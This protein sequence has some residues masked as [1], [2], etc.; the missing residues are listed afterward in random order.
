MEG[1]VADVHAGKSA[2]QG[3]G[4]AEAERAGTGFNEIPAG[5]GDAG[6]RC[7]ENPRGTDHVKC[8]VT[9]ANR[10]GAVQGIGARSG[11]AESASVKVDDRR[12]AERSRGGWGGGKGYQ[13]ARDGH[14]REGIRPRQGLRA[15]AHLVHRASGDQTAE[16]GGGVVVAQGESAAPG[17]HRATS[18]QAVDGFAES[19][20]VEGA[21]ARASG[22][23]NDRAGASTVG[24]LVGGTESQGRAFAGQGTEVDDRVTRV[25]VGGASIV[26][27]DVEGSGTRR[28]GS[29]IQ[30]Q[31][32]GTGDLSR[33]EE[34]T[35]RTLGSEGCRRQISSDFTR[36]SLICVIRPDT[37][38]VI[39][40][41]GVE[42]NR[43]GQ[44][45]TCRVKVNARQIGRCLPNDDRAS[46]ISSCDDS[47][48]CEA[49]ACPAAVQE[50][51]AAG[52]GV[53]R[54]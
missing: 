50:H 35:S 32:G 1:A 28:L 14:R 19:S 25:I 44:R 13:A 46:A 45:L 54:V 27:R 52:E 31:T 42:D 4:P 40:E 3:G 6:P 8:A 7:G 43:I 26:Q 5:A 11:V 20:E 41:R 53:E 23:E 15:A 33:Q 36:Q 24:N 49:G 48:H 47:S 29:D 30:H 9:R 18:A 12:V 21:D 22:V 17:C 39:A 51:H 38:P 34:A 10:G 2:I 16:A 37:H